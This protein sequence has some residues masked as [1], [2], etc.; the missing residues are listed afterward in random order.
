MYCSSEQSRAEQVEVESV[1]HDVLCVK[2]ATQ[3][4]FAEA[5][6]GDSVNFGQPNSARRVAELGKGLRTL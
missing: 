6:D 1:P 2:E 4:G 5:V 3:K